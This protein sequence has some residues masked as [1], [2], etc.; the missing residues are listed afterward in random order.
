[1]LE[2]I[3][4]C[5]HCNTSCTR[6]TNEE[7]GPSLRGQK[8]E[9]SAIPVYRPVRFGLTDSTGTVA[10]ME[11]TGPVP[12]LILNPFPATE[13]PLKELFHVNFVFFSAK[14][15]KIWTRCAAL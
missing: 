7:D 2:T 3:E 15:V 12:S 9:K 14:S 4:I 11:K 13:G 5:Y 6:T 1:M 10:G 8:N